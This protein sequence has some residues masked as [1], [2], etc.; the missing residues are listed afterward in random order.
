VNVFLAGQKSFGAEVLKL[1]VM[2][3][4]YV[5]GVA[6]PKTDDKLGQEAINMDI[7]FHHAPTPDAIPEDT[8]LIVAAH[9]HEFIDAATRERAEMGAIGYHPSL[10][11]LFKGKTAVQDQIDHGCRVSGGSVYWLNDELDGG[12]VVAQ[13]YCFVREDDDASSLWRRELFPMGL[14]LLGE[15]LDQID[16]C[17]PYSMLRYPMTTA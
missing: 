10:L 17:G 2:R 4:H 12:P 1:L 7:L 13:G 16:D 11:P 3:G 14:R 9:C 15:V 5:N 8:D 6:A